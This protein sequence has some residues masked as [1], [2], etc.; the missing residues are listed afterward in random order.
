MDD[1]AFCR[2][3]YILQLIVAA[4]NPRGPRNGPRVATVLFHHSSKYR[5]SFLFNLDDQ[6]SKDVDDNIR[7]VVY[8][9]YGV[10]NLGLRRENL[11]YP[12][13]RALTTLPFSALDMVDKSIEANGNRRASVITLTDGKSHQSVK[14][15][16]DKLRRV[17]DPLIA[18]GIGADVDVPYLVHLASNSSTV[19]YEP[20]RDNAISL[21]IKIV[22]IMR[23][24]AAL[25]PEEGKEIQFLCYTHVAPYCN[26][27]ICCY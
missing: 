7:R 18:A 9:Y 1:A 10:K 6:C 22:E 14:N 19:V 24:T 3:G 17:S 4:V 15:V 27:A 2:F 20:N 23:D 11:E 13:V 8:E 12:N 5:A 21:G 25:C 26:Y 16:V